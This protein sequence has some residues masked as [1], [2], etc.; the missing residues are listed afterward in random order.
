MPLLDRLLIA[1]KQVVT[2][3][4]DSEFY[5]PSPDQNL[6]LGEFGF[7]IFRIAQRTFEQGD[8]ISIGLL[9]LENP[10]SSNSP[11]RAFEKFSDV[12][13]FGTCVLYE[14]RDWVAQNKDIEKLEQ[15]HGKG[16]GL[17]SGADQLDVIAGHTTQHLRQLYSVLDGLGITPVNKVHDSELPPEYVLTLLS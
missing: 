17:R 2:Q 14:Y 12:V 9:P 13:E 16:S 4:P 3:L 6:S 7:H 11:H 5:Q 8:G 15:T 10:I 1:V